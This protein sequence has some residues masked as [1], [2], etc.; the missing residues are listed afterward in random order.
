MLIIL[1]AVVVLPM[2]L[3]AKGVLV[4]A[5]VLSAPS[6]RPQAGEEMTLRF[7]VLREAELVLRVFD[8]KDRRVYEENLGRFFPGEYFFEWKGRDIAARIVPGGFYRCEVYARTPDKKTSDADYV[9]VEARNKKNGAADAGS[10]ITQAGLS[11]FVRARTGFNTAGLE[12]SRGE[13][14]LRVNGGGRNWAYDMEFLPSYSPG[15]RFAWNDLFYKTFI[16]YRVGGGNVYAGYRNYLPGY[17]DPLNLFADYMMGGDRISLG[18]DLNIAGALNLSCGA[19]QSTDRGEIGFETRGTYD[20]YKNLRVASCILNNVSS[21]RLNNVVGI[22]VNA[23]IGSADISAQAATA[24]TSLQPV[25]AMQT[26]LNGNAF[27]IGINTRLF[28][29]PAAGSFRVWVDPEWIDKDFICDFADQ[30]N[31]SDVFGGEIGG[32]YC[33]DPGLPFLRNLRVGIRKAYFLNTSCTQTIQKFKPSLSAQLFEGL[34]VFLHYNY[35]GGEDITGA[36]PVQVSRRRNVFTRLYYR[37]PGGKWDLSAGYTTSCQLPQEYTS[38]Q[39]VYRY[40]PVHGLGAS[41]GYEKI[42]SSSQDG[43]DRQNCYGWSAGASWLILPQYETELSLQA[44]LVNHENAAPGSSKMVYYAG[45]RHYFIE[46]LSGA[47]AYGSMSSTSPDDSAYAELKYE[48]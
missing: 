38:T 24:L 12:R 3:H 25:G 40:L 37:M 27:K 22:D 18:G 17:N 11:G 34:D 8:L 7:C 36:V 20:L 15:E 4:N 47:A 10:G 35:L 14:Y 45:M 42:A 1:C 23:V 32:E 26:Q 39:V 19:H 44:K 21:S 28:D 46:G 43:S 9:V 16:N 6:F 29:S 33:I 31:G 13:I 48:F 30:A 5:G 41:A 2:R